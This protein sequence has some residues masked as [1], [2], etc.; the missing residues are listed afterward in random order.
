MFTFKKTLK[1]NVIKRLWPHGV[2]FLPPPQ[3]Q[4]AKVNA[5]C[6]ALQRALKDCDEC[7]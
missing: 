5:T 7:I 4:A 1:K 3:I 2:F 6:G